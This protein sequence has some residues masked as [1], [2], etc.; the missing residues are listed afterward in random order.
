MLQHIY[1]TLFPLSTS[2]ITSEQDTY[3]TEINEHIV[4]YYLSTC[5]LYEHMLLSN[6]MVN[7]VDT[8][9]V[10]AKTE[11]NSYLSSKNQN[12]EDFVNRVFDL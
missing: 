5:Q 6:N 12:Y 4:S 2:T 9:D 1:N 3:T 8:A 7:I 10:M 11:Q